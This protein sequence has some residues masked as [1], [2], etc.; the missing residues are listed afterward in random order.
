MADL[1][2]N[3]T[4]VKELFYKNDFGIIRCN[5]DKVLSGELKTD[6][7]AT[8]FK[9]KMPRIREG[10]GYK[11]AADYTEDKK[12]G[13]Q[14]NIR[15][16]TSAITLDDK[17][18]NSKRKYLESIFTK[19]QV[20]QMYKDISDPYSALRDGNATELVKISGCGMYRASE[21]INR[22]QKE[23]RRALIY[24]E[25]HD[26]NLSS[27]IIDKLLN[28]YNS[29]DMVIQKVKEDP[30]V[31]ITEVRGI[32]WATAD[33]I[34]V[35]G[36]MSLDDPKRVKAYMYQYLDDRGAEGFS[37]I[38]ED[39]FLGAILEQF[40]EDI[41]DE[42]I[43]EA[44]QLLDP[45][46]W[47]DKEEKKIG[48]K[49]F[50]N[51]ENKIATE[52]LRIRDA[53]TKFQYE[54]V[55]KAIKRIE[56]LQGWEYT[57]EQKIAIKKGLENNIIIIQG[58]AG[59]G[60]SSMVKAILECSKGHSFVQCAFSGKAASR[61]MEVTAQE[62][63]T[64][65]RLLGFPTG[66]EEKQRFAFND[67]NPLGYDIYIIDEISMVDMKL[68][69]YLLRAIP[70]GSK[71][72][73]L[74]DN[75]QLEAI[76]AGNIA[77]DLLA[78]PEIEACTLTKIHR[79]AEESAIVTESV[80]IRNKQQIIPEDWVG[81]EVRGQLQDLDLTC[82]SDNANTYYEIMKAFNIEW[83]KSDKSP[84]AIM[85]I[86][87]LSPMKNRGASTYQLNNVIQ[88]ICNGRPARQE[89]ISSQYGGYYLKVGDKVINT[90]NNY[91]TNPN[92]FNGNIGILKRFEQKEDEDG[93]TNEYMIIDFDGIGEVR[94]LDEYWKNI[95][96]AYALTVHKF[97]GSQAETVIFGFDFSAFSLLTKELVY[98]GITRAMK[99]CYLIAQNKALRYATT[100]SEVKNKQT[101]LQKCLHDQA[102][103]KIIF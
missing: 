34:A 78:T 98:T 10:E 69:Y 19:N 89:F 6:R 45:F 8:V 67:E 47:R 66:P 94:V 15:F 37:W 77:F 48:L 49:Y 55:E 101:H 92:I 31:L 83:N 12:F 64:I 9:G 60:K 85:N 95:E 80:K 29:A 63:F 56:T 74:G 2:C 53:E 90:V 57:E 33:N 16:L 7:D 35:A 26:Y 30:Y 61:L 59:T 22:F 82:Y 5:V 76:G 25:L 75:G 81:H 14:Y 84:R 99:K 17:N 20:E 46:L 86:Q 52:L 44:V 38:T 51:Y 13:P 103:P 24:A 91:K 18:E 3:V 73:C 36:G 43:I 88:E 71:V 102:H 42:R 28:T 4:V 27:A 93:H 65:H 39:E 23:Y 79:Q 87:V 100:H 68:F 50:F 70:S 11:I 1:E 96:L 72:I 97:Q 32:G 62:G 58:G 41:P 40:G 21:W 54:N